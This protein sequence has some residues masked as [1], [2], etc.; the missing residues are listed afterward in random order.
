M[1]QFSEVLKELREE[2]GFNMTAL[3][4]AAGLSRPYLSQLESG[5]RNPTP[6]TLKKLAE[7]LG[8]VTY[9]NLLES[10]GFQDLSEN[11]KIRSVYDDFDI[12]I[13]F[14]KMHELT[15]TIERMKD[16]KVFLEGHTATDDPP[17]FYN[18][19]KMTDQDRQRV[20]NVLKELFPEYADKE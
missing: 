19:H 10:A 18:G 7:A 9:A 15:S 20:L 3:A 11:E 16:I 1:K 13:D 8:N 5:K 17:P 14:S 4:K 12:D 2:T 6:D